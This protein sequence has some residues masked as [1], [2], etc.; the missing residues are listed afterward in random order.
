[1]KCRKQLRLPATSKAVVE[2]VMD[3][4]KSLASNS[5]QRNLR[6]FDV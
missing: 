5:Y 1:M 6:E 2:G 4:E 3:L